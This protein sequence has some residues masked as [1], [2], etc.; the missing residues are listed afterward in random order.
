MEQHVITGNTFPLI[1]LAILAVVI[2]ITSFSLTFFRKA[3][4]GDTKH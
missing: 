2:M 1:C 3:D 4:T